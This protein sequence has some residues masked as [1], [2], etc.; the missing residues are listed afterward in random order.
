MNESIVLDINSNVDGNKDNVMVKT[1]MYRKVSMKIY[2]GF[3]ITASQDKG[4][5]MVLD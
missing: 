1:S 2:A 3:K 5:R 4:L